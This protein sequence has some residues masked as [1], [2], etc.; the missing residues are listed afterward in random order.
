MVANSIR[1]GSTGEACASIGILCSSRTRQIVRDQCAALAFALQRLGVEAA[2]RTDA[3]AHDTETPLLLEPA[4]TAAALAPAG[5]DVVGRLPETVCVSLARPFTSELADDVPW[6]AGAA[7]AYAVHPGAARLLRL[8]VP[9]L[10]RLALGFDPANSA[11]DGSSRPRPIGVAFIG[12]GGGDRL[13][14]LASCADE[15][16]RHDAELYVSRIGEPVLRRSRASLL[17]DAQLVIIASPGEGSAVDS[18][19]LAEAAGSGA[20]ALV[21]S[22][23]DLAPYE[24]GEHVLVTTEDALPDALRRAFA[25]P[26]R[27]EAIRTR[28]RALASEQAATAD[29][30]EELIGALGL[31]AATAHP[32][33]LARPAAA[34]ATTAARGLASIAE[35]G[36]TRT[37]NWPME[38][39]AGWQAAS[40]DVSVVV[41]VLD[42]A[43]FITA[44]AASAL[45]SVGVCVELIVVDDGSTDA[46]CDVVRGIMTARPAA[47]VTLIRRPCRGGIGAARNDGFAV[48]RATLAFALDVDNSLFPHGLQ[49]LA[50]ALERD[51]IAVFSYGYHATHDG[52]RV[53]GLYNTEDWDPALFRSGNYIDANALLRVEL[54]RR[55]GGYDERPL[56][57]GWEDF[58]YWLRCAA[59]GLRGTHAHAI[60]LR[61]ALRA[62]SVS[63]DTNQ[64]AIAIRELLSEDYGSLLGDNAQRGQAV[65]RHLTSL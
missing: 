41:P 27:L 53:S 10:R 45:D 50:A 52:G 23:G 11:W 44:A 2:V 14:L 17:A 37:V 33:A 49:A 18:L 34:N 55:L 30:A 39:S 19:D 40:P 32:T 12:H 36:Y 22:P 65:D 26:G 35:S 31:A 4:A 58:E 21:V 24:P 54:W 43:R 8:R 47:A 1:S 60:V 15:L 5:I 28:A 46:T 61:Y 42:G 51:P 57:H 25:V 59:A 63:A 56:V 7:H 13:R 16:D 9:G 48:A 6:L 29:G 38:H 20:V 62:D 64:R 3:P